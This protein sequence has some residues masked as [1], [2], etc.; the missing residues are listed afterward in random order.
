MAEN[1]R[2]PVT[3]NELVQVSKSLMSI[4]LIKLI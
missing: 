3:I 2:S 4:L 1:K